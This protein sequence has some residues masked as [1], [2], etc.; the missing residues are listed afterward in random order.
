MATH[1][2]NEAVLS[3]V[4]N[5]LPHLVE[6]CGPVRIHALGIWEDRDRAVGEEERLRVLAPPADVDAGSRNLAG[7]V[8]RGWSAEL[9]A[10]RH[11][12]RLDRSSGGDHDPPI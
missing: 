6:I 8:D 10:V 2:R 5:H 4:A 9:E 12:N 11:G 3:C 7:I 1:G